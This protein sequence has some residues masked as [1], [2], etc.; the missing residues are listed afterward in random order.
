MEEFLR[1]WFEKVGT[2]ADDIVGRG[3]LRST[4]ESLVPAL[5]KAIESH[6]TADQ[7]QV[8]RVFAGQMLVA[9]SHE[10]HSR[11]DHETVESLRQ[12]LTETVRCYLQD[13][14]YLLRS[15]LALDVVCDPLLRE[16]FEVRVGQAQLAKTAP[17][18]WLQ[19]ADGRRILL[20]L[21]E[22]ES[23]RR[24]TLGRIGDNDIVID[25]QTVSRFHA[26]LSL[27]QTG[28]IVVSDL[29][30]ANGTFVNGWRIVGAEVVN[31]DDELTVGSV[32][33]VLVEG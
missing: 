31:L 3:G 9:L 11:M 2:R 26:A 28:D 14:R 24:L 5:Y 22:A 15:K 29:G 25:H 32:S 20:P 27:N 8:K 13:H 18:R 16:P 19:G 4:I 10:I 23:P 1:K 17:R 21:G 30:S 33:F 6:L 7:Q 12:E